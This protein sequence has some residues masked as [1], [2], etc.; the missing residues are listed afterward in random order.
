MCQ[1]LSKE[2]F[3]LWC[4]TLWHVWYNR[5]NV[6]EDKMRDLI[7]ILEAAS[8]WWNEYRNHVSSSVL[9]TNIANVNNAIHWKPPDPRKL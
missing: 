2:D 3:E 5:N 9:G 4:I 8:S 7:S 1:N 6:H